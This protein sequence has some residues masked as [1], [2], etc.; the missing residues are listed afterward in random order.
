VDLA[1]DKVRLS[2][3]GP[4]RDEVQR[5]LGQG[6]LPASVIV[7]GRIAQA[8]IED[9]LR[10]ADFSVLLREPRR[11]AQ[12]GFPTKVPESMAVGTPLICNVTSDLGR[13]LRDGV[14]GIVAGD[15]EPASFADALRRALALSPAE[16]LA[17][18]AA[19][20]AE[21]ERAFDFRVHADPLRRFLEGVRR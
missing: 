15:H 4:A 8:D 17:M 21:A 18:R 7:K 3:Y 11:F 16:R 5:L 12:A 10:Q 9:A 1:G 19:S 13:H 2:V 6:D 14:N 20:R